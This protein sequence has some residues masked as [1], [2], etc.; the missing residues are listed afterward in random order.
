[1][2]EKCNHKERQGFDK[3]DFD[4]E[5]EEYIKDYSDLDYTYDLGF[6]LCKGKINNTYSENDIEN[7]LLLIGRDVSI[8]DI[9]GSDMG[10]LRRYW[11]EM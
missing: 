1:M 11:V 8:K 7:D 4:R 6:N 2:I 9:S 3:R 5:F 10:K